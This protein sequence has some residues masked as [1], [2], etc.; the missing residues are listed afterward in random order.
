M[1]YEQQLNKIL[2]PKGCGNGFGKG[3]TD[4]P[5]YSCN[6]K[7]LCPTCKEIQKA[8]IETLL[9]CAKNEIEDFELLLNMLDVDEFNVIGEW[10]NN[11]I[12]QLQEVI[13]KLEE[14]K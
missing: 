5:K 8:Q 1:N 3:K 2:N 9:I 6:E 12:S 13:K 11:K 4:I 10:I 7:H 14:I